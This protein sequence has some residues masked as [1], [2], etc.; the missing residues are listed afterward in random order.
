MLNK[1]YPDNYIP[2][3]LWEALEYIMEDLSPVSLNIIRHS[4]TEILHHN[5]GRDMRNE[6]GL[7]S[8]GEL[9]KWFNAELGI[10]HPDDMSGIILE[11]LKRTVRQ[12][13]LKLDEQVKFYKDYWKNIADGEESF[14]IEC[15]NNK[16]MTIRGVT[17]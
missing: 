4:D 13:D 17:L 11:S 1:K 14:M 16:M 8:G 2:K 15:N 3:T 6:W 12:E 7:W 5:I 10:Y 9:A